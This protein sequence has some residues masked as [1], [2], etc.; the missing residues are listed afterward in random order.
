MRQILIYLG[1]NLQKQAIL[2]DILNDVNVA[3]TFLNDDDLNDTLGYLLKLENFAKNDKRTTLHCSI[4]FMYL[5]D[6]SDEMIFTLNELMKAK[7]ISMPRKGMRTPTNI[8]WKLIDLLSEIEAEHTYFEKMEQLYKLLQ[9]SSELIIER[10]TSES[11]KNYE[12]AFYDGYQW[13]QKQGELKD[14]ELA[15]E[16]L[17]QAKLDLILK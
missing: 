9:D 5:D 15:I 17:K 1:D 2:D 7:G 13:M 16:K 14:I 3:H 12:Q 10:Y 6:I 8:H 11:W 4:D